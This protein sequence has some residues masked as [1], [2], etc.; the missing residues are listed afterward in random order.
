MWVREQ[1]KSARAGALQARPVRALAL[2]PAAKR[3]QS[4]AAVGLEQ[5][6]LRLPGQEP[7]S[8]LGLQQQ[9][10]RADLPA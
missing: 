2:T 1:A 8:A 7:A 3:L 6:P 9:P 4:Q 10:E 5:L